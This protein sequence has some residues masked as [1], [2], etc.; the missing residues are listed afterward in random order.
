MINLDACI[1]CGSSENLNTSMNIDVDG[2]K[3]T[4]WVCDADA[5][6]ITPK[7]ARGYY[8]AKKSEIDEVIAKARALGLEVTMPD[9]PGAIA[10]ARRRPEVGCPAPVPTDPT[11][12][13]L[14]SAIADSIEGTKE[15]GVLPTSVVDNVAQR[16]QGVSGGQAGAESHSAYIPGT[17]QDKLDPTLLE[18]KVKMGVGE[19][20]GG[21]AIA[22]PS[23][24]V[25]QTGTTTVRV[26]KTIDDSIL[27]RRFKEM[28][29]S[30]GPDGANKHSFAQGGYDVH[31]CPICKG[32]GVIKQRGKLETC[33]KCEG[34]GLLNT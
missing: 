17:G 22:I 30:V 12:P 3:I 10:T 6:D 34:T 5:E 24:R 23:V 32:D 14:D 7:Q 4:A 25:D 29:G 33:P 15:E 27:Q 31:T 26:Q 21:Q 20:R 19:G 11:A 28:A 2:K 18:G 13:A 9:A 8:L 1:V 16:V